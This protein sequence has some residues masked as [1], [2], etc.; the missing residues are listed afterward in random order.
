[1]RVGL[2]LPVAGHELAAM[3]FERYDSVDWTTDLGIRYEIPYRRVALT[4]AADATN[5]LD[6]SSFVSG[7]AF[8]GSTPRSS[9]PLSRANR[10]FGRF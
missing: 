5:V 8:A 3:A 6:A 9:E 2:Q 10:T 1:M 7:R 4:L